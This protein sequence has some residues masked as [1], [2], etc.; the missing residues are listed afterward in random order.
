MPVA[1]L[2]KQL[3]LHASF[4]RNGDT[5]SLEIDHSQSHLLNDSTKHQLIDAMHH[6]LGENVNV[7]IT[8]GEPSTTPFA[9]QQEIHAMRHAHA[10][11]VVNTDDTIQALLSTFD[12]SV[13]TDTVKAR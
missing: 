5:V 10:H 12:A 8:L 2:L 9:L 6:G 7:D 1:G 11:S 3:V 13:L 4:A